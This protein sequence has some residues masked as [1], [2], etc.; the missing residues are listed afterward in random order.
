MYG[1]KEG[2]TE[3]RNDVREIGRTEERKEERWTEEKEGKD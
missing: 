3:G 1:M 2:W